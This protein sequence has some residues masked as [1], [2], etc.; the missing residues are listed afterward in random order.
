MAVMEMQKAFETAIIR[1]PADA[2][3][4]GIYADW[5]DEQERPLMVRVKRKNMPM[6]EVQ[7]YLMDWYGCL[8]GYMESWTPKSRNRHW[9]PIGK[10]LLLV[11][12]ERFDWKGLKYWQPLRLIRTLD[13]A[14]F[15]TDRTRKMKGNPIRW[16]HW[17]RQRPNDKEEN[18]ASPRDHRP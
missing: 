17:F 14:I 11:E 3:A 6:S 4:R 15:A 12:W 5:L 9:R 10:G 2:A 1:N 8:S 18:H 7:R 13:G 16:L